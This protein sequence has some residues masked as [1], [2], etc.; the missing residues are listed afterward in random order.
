MKF[1]FSRKNKKNIISLSSAELAHS[2]VSVK[3]DYE[4]F[5]IDTFKRLE[6]Q[7]GREHF[8]VN[9]YRSVSSLHSAF[10]ALLG[11]AVKVKRICLKYFAEI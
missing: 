8:I 11:T 2:M 1:F 10:A 7:F 3:S 9:L 5:G 4:F 6:L